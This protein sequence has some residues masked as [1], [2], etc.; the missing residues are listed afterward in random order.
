[1]ARDEQYSDEFG[2]QLSALVDD[3]LSREERAFLLRRLDHDGQARARL[4]RYHLMR[5]ALQR[6]LPEQPR[7]DLVERVR[8][9]L[10]EDPPH[11]QES[12]PQPRGW[13]R[14]ALGGAIAAT[15]AAVTVLWWQGGVPMGGVNE[16]TAGGEVV[17]SSTEREA[18]P[19]QQ[20]DAGATEARAQAGAPA[21]AVTFGEGAAFPWTTSTYS[22]PAL[23][24]VGDT[25]QARNEPMPERLHRFMIDHAEQAE[26]D[27]PGSM[28]QHVRVPEHEEP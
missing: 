16:P 22:L 25:Q 28:L 27:Y 18:E 13:R 11:T 9:G 10:A 3:E 17:E 7:T 5:D 26:S 4:A 15:V 6:S 8:A 2:E 12:V 1:M 24:T 20:A 19:R 14:P 23:Q 21:Q